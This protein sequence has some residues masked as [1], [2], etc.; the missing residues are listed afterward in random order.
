MQAVA[1]GAPSASSE[2]PAT[3]VQ[4][5]AAAAGTTSPPSWREASRDVHVV[6]YTTGWC[7]HCREAKAWMKANGVSYD[8][9]DIE[10]SSDNARQNRSVNPRGSIPTFDVEGDVMVGFSAGDLTSMIERAAQRHSRRN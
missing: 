2:E 6:V 8:E 9:R 4:A 5:N 7:P 1:H 10:A 3:V